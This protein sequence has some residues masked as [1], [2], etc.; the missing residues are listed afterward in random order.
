MI[1]DCEMI[2]DIGNQNEMPFLGI[3]EDLII[4]SSSEIKDYTSSCYTFAEQP[5]FSKSMSVKKTE[6]LA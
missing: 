3:Q 5:A 2:E 4:E 1:V 6:R